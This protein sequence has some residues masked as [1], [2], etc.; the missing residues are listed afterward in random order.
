MPSMHAEIPNRAGGMV[1]GL[2]L[3]FQ[4]TA[5]AARKLVRALVNRRRVARELE[6]LANKDPDFYRQ[7]K[8]WGY[9]MTVAEIGLVVRANPAFG[10]TTN[11]V[12][13]SSGA[14]MT[15]IM[16]RLLIITERLQC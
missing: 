5:G 14:T 10:S 3:G 7:N 11:G 13:V 1:G 16:L 6:R 12:S 15:P 4:M 8:L 9:R 2:D